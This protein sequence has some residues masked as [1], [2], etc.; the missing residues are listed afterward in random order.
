M[1]PI[2]ILRLLLLEFASAIK[3]FSKRSVCRDVDIT[4]SGIV[5]GRY[6]AVKADITQAVY[7]I[8]TVIQNNYII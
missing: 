8:K 3:V 2:D 7:L 4:V 6:Y 1:V 5:S